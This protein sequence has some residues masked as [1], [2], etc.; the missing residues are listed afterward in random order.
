MVIFPFSLW[1]AFLNLWHNYVSC[2][3][4][5]PVPDQWLNEICCFLQSGWLT[6]SWASV[7]ELPTSLLPPCSQDSQQNQWPQL[8]LLGGLTALS[9]GRAPTCNV[10]LGHRGG[11]RKIRSILGGSLLFEEIRLRIHV[12][13]SGVRS[14]DPVRTQKA[15]NLFLLNKPKASQ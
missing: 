8:S 7:W 15:Q 2:P 14:F 3:H 5:R 6:G 12:G 4:L 11:S 10:C 13:G 1:M 9:G